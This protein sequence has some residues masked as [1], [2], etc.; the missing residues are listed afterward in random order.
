MKMHGNYH[1]KTKESNLMKKSDEVE[2]L[3]LFHKMK[4]S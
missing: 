2:D 3:G 4:I 1:L